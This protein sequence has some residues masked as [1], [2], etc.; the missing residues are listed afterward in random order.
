MD[1]EAVRRAVDAAAK[2]ITERMR[3]LVDGKLDRKSE[4]YL[5]WVEQFSCWN[6]A[7][8][9]FCDDIGVDYKSLLP[10]ENR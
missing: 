10:K 5:A 4:H 1:E 9:K 2:P 8:L 7:D 3:L 6:T